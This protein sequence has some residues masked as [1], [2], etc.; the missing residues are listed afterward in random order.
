MK[1]SFPNLLMAVAVVVLFSVAYAASA[2]EVV[3]STLPDTREPEEIFA[4]RMTEQT[5]DAA[6]A[7]IGAL[8]EISIENAPDETSDAE[9][10]DSVTALEPS[11]LETLSYGFANQADVFQ[12]PPY[13]RF[14]LARY[15]SLYGDTYLAKQLY[16]SE[17]DSWRGNAY[18]MVATACILAGE[19]NISPSIFHDGAQTVSALS[20]SDYNSDWGMSLTDFIET[21]QISQTSSTFCATISRNLEHSDKLYELV[22]AYEADGKYP[23]TLCLFNSMT[24]E[25]HALIPYRIE[26]DSSGQMSRLYVYDPNYPLDDSRF[27]TFSGESEPI[28]N[29]WEYTL[30]DEVLWGSDNGCQ[31]SFLTCQDC[32]SLWESRGKPDFRSV[33]LTLNVLDAT[34][35]DVETR[36][37]A[38]FRD[39]VIV[40]ESGNA[41]P[42]YKSGISSGLSV[43]LPTDEVY[44]I[45]NDELTPERLEASLVNV[46]QKIMLETNAHSAVLSVEDITAS[47]YVRLPEPGCDYTIL[48]VADL[49]PQYETLRM[50]GVT[51]DNA[52]LSVSEAGGVLKISGAGESDHLYLNGEERSIDNFHLIPVYSNSVNPFTDVSPEQ[53]YYQP[54]LWA[55]KENITKGTSATAFSPQQSCTRAHILTFLW[56]ANGSPEPT[57]SNPFSDVISTSYYAKAAAWSYEKGIETENQFHGE[58]PCTRA[59]VV[60]YLWKLSGC[61]DAEESDFK[62]VS[63]STELSQAIDWAVK[64]GVTK[65]TSESTFSP[66]N[67]C[68]RGQIVTFLYRYY[69]EKRNQ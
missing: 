12:Y 1:S 56:R 27:L 25:E 17:F 20:L 8:D 23:I 28:W 47:S 35:R 21:M 32:L 42:I 16:A 14:P 34:I 65:G 40:E 61:P 43:W 55:V 68:T 9:M 57:V 67:V 60:M 64:C 38:V 36:P 54:I 66:D 5:N 24:G 3:S 45:S 22:S 29:H 13:Y 26:T 33:L 62:D 18:G 41:H 51:S 63:K 7:P 50:Q 49:A 2:T 58:N 10:P 48:F 11:R 53:Y 37:V 19:N 39:G 6:E 30:H 44:S 69:M 59:A 46:R 15:Q 52:S 31:F 4:E